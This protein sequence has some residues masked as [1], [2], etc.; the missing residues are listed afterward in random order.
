MKEH[1]LLFREAMI[2]A[3]LDN[4]KTQT[5]R[6]VTWFNS[7]LDGARLGHKGRQRQIWDGLD[8][9]QASVD[10]GPS[11]TGNPG[12]YFKVPCP[13]E[14]TV[15]RVSPIYQPGDL[16]WAKES[17]QLATGKQL[18]DLAAAIR[19]RDGVIKAVTM[20]ADRPMPLGLTWDKWRP[21]IHMPR[22]GSRITREIAQLRPQFLQEISDTDAV[23]E[24]LTHDARTGFFLPGQC[25]SPRWAFEILWDSINAP[26]GLAW[27]ANPPVWAFIFKPGTELKD[28]ACD[29]AHCYSQHGKR[30]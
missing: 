20:P 25:A 24:G 22:W 12:P 17:C 7:C 13:T 16:I 18:G 29:A 2:K 26:R 15:H 28:K 3:L 19:Y 30:A 21:S 10:P 6:V 8:W 23:A 14:S 27:A 4:R 5:R 11:P 1:P 9:S